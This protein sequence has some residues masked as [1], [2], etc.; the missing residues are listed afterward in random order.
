MRA[1]LGMPAPAANATPR[2]DARRLDRRGTHLSSRT[3][4]GRTMT[5]LAAQWRSNGRL[6]H[7]RIDQLGG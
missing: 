2:R 7:R 4:V 6:R 1:R 3:R 5:A